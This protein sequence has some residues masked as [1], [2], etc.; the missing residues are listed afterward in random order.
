MRKKSRY[1]SFLKLGK[2]FNEKTVF[3][4]F[5]SFFS[6]YFFDRMRRSLGVYFLGKDN[7]L[8]N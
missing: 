2:I 7:I 4:F 8:F 1:D 5:V 6:L 3:A